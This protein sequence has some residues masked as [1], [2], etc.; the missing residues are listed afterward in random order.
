MASFIG[1]SVPRATLARHPVHGWPA[2]DE[3]R[4]IGTPCRLERLLGPLHELDAVYLAD[5]MLPELQV[6]LA[7]LDATDDPAR[8]PIAKSA[9]PVGARL[10]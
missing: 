10:P 4:I 6:D 1:R 7:C 3:P 9:P 8:Y 2:R 5:D